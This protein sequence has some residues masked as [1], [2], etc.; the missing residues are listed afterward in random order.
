MKYTVYIL[1]YRQTDSLSQT[2]YFQARCIMFDASLRPTTSVLYMLRSLKIN[3]EL[4]YEYLKAGIVVLHV[5]NFLTGIA[6]LFEPS[7]TFFFFLI[8]GHPR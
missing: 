7:A 3:I 6:F 5:L 1:P 2:H 8:C 4:I